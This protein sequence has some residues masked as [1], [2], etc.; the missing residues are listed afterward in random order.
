MSIRTIQ[1]ILDENT[2]SVPD[3][4]YVQLSNAIMKAHRV[5]EREIEFF[6]LKK[7]IDEEALDELIHLRGAVVLY[8]TRMREVEV[9]IEEQRR[10]INNYKSLITGQ[11]KKNEEYKKTIEEY[12][13]KVKE[14][15]G[16]NSDQEPLPRPTAVKEP[17]G[18]CLERL[19]Q[20]EEPVPLPNTD[21]LAKWR[22]HVKQWSKENNVNYGE[23][24]RSPACSE[25][26]HRS[27]QPQQN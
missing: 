8:E 12:K 13:R 7:Q 18:Q 21:H 23:A 14:L 9:D 16:K 17:E 11:S 2:G 22:D 10:R 4:I 5:R 6:R 20:T 27:K 1:D 24:M 3:G 26:Y 25:A 15:E 19:R